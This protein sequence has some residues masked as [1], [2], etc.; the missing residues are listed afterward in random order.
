[1]YVIQA[2]ADAVTFTG[3]LEVPGEESAAAS[4]AS[5]DIYMCIYIYIFHL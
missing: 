4:A 5:G 3:T 2:Q 1:M